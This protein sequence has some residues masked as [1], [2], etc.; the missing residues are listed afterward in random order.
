M[1]YKNLTIA[2]EFISRSSISIQELL[3]K[4]TIPILIGSSKVL[5]IDFKSIQRF[6][7]VNISRWWIP[8][9]NDKL[10]AQL[11]NII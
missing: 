5:E 8:E 6:P 10:N 4:S 1:T 7:I 3:M 9:F 11:Y 2:I